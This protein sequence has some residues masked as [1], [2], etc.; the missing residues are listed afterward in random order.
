MIITVKTEQVTCTFSNSTGV[1]LNRNNSQNKVTIKPKNGYRDL[2]N[3]ELNHD[4]HSLVRTGIQS[5]M[6]RLDDVLL[7]IK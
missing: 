1:T 2:K 7:S 5:V 4:N 6:A 3:E